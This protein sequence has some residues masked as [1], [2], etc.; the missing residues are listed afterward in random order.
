MGMLAAVEMW[1]KR[2]HKAEWAEWE[3]RLRH[4]AGKAEKVRGVTTEIT[5]PSPDLSNRSPKLTIHWDGAKL[6]ITGTELSKTIL[7][8]EPRIVLAG[9]AGARPASMASNVSIIPYQMMPGDEKIVGDRIY[10]L[11]SKPPRFSDPAPAP[12]GTPVSVN[13]EWKARLEFGRGTA[14]H[15][16]MLTQDG[17]KL[18]ASTMVNS[19][20]VTSTARWRRIR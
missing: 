4:I 3:S 6:G 17:S 16:I 1:L 20:K 19:S 9:A 15:T 14:T 10:A 12:S 2:D 5:Q 7:N 18:P 8:S 13:G 11:L